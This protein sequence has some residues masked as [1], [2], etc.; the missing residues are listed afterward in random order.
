M[1]KSHHFFA[2]FV[3]RTLYHYTG[4]SSL[5]YIAE[6]NRLWASHV[7]YLNDSREIVHACS[8]LKVLLEGQIN[9]HQDDEREFLQQLADWVKSFEQ[10]PYHLF[11]F[12]LSEEPNLLSQWRSY[13]PHGKGVCLGFSQGYLNNML[14]SFKSVRMEILL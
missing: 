11:I 5:L 8:I 13:T 4:I 6:N 3:N 2:P 7:Y 1:R 12:S 9:K 14:V 10:T